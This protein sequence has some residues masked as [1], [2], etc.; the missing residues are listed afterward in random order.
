MQGGWLCLSLGHAILFK[1]LEFTPF[2][3]KNFREINQYFS[4]DKY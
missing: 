3:L 2:L 4:E 1:I